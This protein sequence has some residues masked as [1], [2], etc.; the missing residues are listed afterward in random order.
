MVTDPR[1][2]SE[3]LPLNRTKRNRRNSPK[4]T[5]PHSSSQVTDAS[6]GKYSYSQ[7]IVSPAAK[8]LGRLPHRPLFLPLLEEFMYVFSQFLVLSMHLFNRATV[9]RQGILGTTQSYS[10][11]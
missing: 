10:P 2:D 9:F 11:Y 3:R 8:G 7:R 5:P 6:R 4:N 1:L